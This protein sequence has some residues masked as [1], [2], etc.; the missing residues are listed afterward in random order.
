MF[1]FVQ[2]V[3]LRFINRQSVPAVV[4]F[5]CH[6]P[7]SRL[8]SSPRHLSISHHPFTPFLAHLFLVTHSLF[9]SLL[10]V[11]SLFF[12]IILSLHALLALTSADRGGAALKCLHKASL[13]SHTPLT[14]L[15]LLLLLLLPF[16]PQSPLP[17][18][19]TDRRRVSWLW[20]R[21]LPLQRRRRKRR[22]RRMET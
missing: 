17:L 19:L 21:K 2:P 11:L 4:L 16:F 14:L 22:R 8:G 10:S 9:V 3:S 1:Y 20:F 15:L 13:T 12:P 18:S 7:A 6:F 5:F